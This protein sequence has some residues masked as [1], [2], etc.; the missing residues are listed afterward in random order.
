VSE[1]THVASQENKADR[2]GNLSAVDL[3]AALAAWKKAVY[4]ADLSDNTQR[5]YY[6]RARRFVDWLVGEYDLP[7]EMDPFDGRRQRVSRD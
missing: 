6:D 2:A 7:G 4:E 1:K 5:T 3:R